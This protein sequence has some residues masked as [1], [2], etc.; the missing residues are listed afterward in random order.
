[1]PGDLELVVSLKTGDTEALEQ[2]I[3]RWRSG[4][5]AYACSLLLR[6]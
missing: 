2:L 6:G 3:G 5:E 4:A 1:M